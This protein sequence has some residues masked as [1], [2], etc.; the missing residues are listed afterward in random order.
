MNRIIFILILEISFCLNFFA[1]LSDKQQI[2]IVKEDISRMEHCIFFFNQQKNIKTHG[3]KQ[4]VAFVEVK[5]NSM[6]DAEFIDFCNK[7]SKQ[8]VALERTFKYNQNIS[9]Y[10]I[11][12]ACNR[13]GEE[14][15]IN[16][17]CEAVIKPQI[18]NVDLAEQLYEVKAQIRGESSM[19]EMLGRRINYNL[20][21]VGNNVINLGRKHAPLPKE[22][23]KIVERV[24]ESNMQKLKEWA[25][26]PN[27]KSIDN[28]VANVVNKFIEIVPIESKNGYWLAFKSVPEAGIV[29][30]H[31]GD[32]VRIFF[33][34]RGHEN[35]IK[36][37]KKK[38]AFLEDEMRR[39]G[40]SPYREDTRIILPYTNPN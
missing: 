10:H 30:G 31:V 27:E 11:I 16:M 5:E 2:E 39:N 12:Y 3:Y 13:K 40:V 1:Q 21:E 25:G 15:V 34:K 35:N 38:E 17:Y 20:I 23:D 4:D 29:F 33:D 18:E 8:V 26:V 36:E 9:A 24:Q 7:Y 28:K 6:S 14:A 22:I 37:L 19:T 32:I